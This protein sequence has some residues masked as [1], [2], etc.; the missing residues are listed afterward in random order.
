MTVNACEPA[1]A[2]GADILQQLVRAL[3]LQAI[4]E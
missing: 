2:P 3:V 1:V 4:E